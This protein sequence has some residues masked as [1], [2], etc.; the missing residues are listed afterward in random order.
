MSENNVNLSSLL[1]MQ[2]D[3]L[4]DLPE[5]VRINKGAHR[6]T[7]EFIAKQVGDHPAWELKM[8]LL[9]TLELSDSSDTPQAP[10]I[11][12]SCVYMM[13]NE[14][15]AGEFKS[16]M[17]PIAAALGVTNI[18]QIIEAIKGSEAAVVIGW[19]HAKDDKDKIYLQVKSLTLV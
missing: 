13:D 14:Y 4:A 2:L 7:V 3:D 17:K 10:G 5:Y 16:I 19:R 1:D 11:E 8:K 6:V 15:G 18:G 9:E 12:S